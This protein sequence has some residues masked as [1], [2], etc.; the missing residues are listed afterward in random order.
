MEKSVVYFTKDISSEGLIKIFNALNITLKGKVAVKISSGEPGGHY[1][2]NPNLIK[3][4][5]DKLHGTIVECC[6]AY[7]GRRFEPKEH[8]E[9]IKE[10]GFYDIA[11]CDIM[12]EFG[13]V[14]IPIEG[15][16]ILKV[17]ILL[18]N[19]LIIMIHYLSYLILKAIKWQVWVEHLK[20]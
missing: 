16:N 8:W 10:H 2:L 15:G 5:V 6:T 3:P 18:E 20:I 12:D 14:K 19:I 7:N 17:T 1:F 4:L 9:A 11:P 13:E